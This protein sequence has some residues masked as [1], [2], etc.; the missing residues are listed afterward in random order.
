MSMP[1]ETYHGNVIG[2]M[3]ESWQ[4]FMENMENSLDLLEEN[5][6]EV[7]EMS[8]ACTS[9]WCEATEHVLD[10]LSNSIFS[11]SE[12]RWA[13][14]EDSDKIKILKNRIHDLYAKYKSVVVLTL[15]LHKSNRK[16]N[17]LRVCCLESTAGGGSAFAATG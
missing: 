5:I 17:D 14:K 4:V 11:I 10:E 8:D 2:K 7:S 9:E 1:K 12:P 16:G 3:G 15:R 6:Q 13:S